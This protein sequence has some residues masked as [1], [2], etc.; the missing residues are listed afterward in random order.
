MASRSLDDLSLPVREA[1]L[2]LISL[3]QA[4]GME[5]LVYCTLRSNEEQAKLYASG[6]TSPGRVLTNARPGES[7]HNPGE[8]GK[9]WAFD[10]VPIVAGKPAWDDE[11]LLNKMGALGERAGLKWAGRW[12]GKLREKVHFEM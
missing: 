12:R 5:L 2:R 7:K 9:A 11:H 8:L 4:E 6:R 3:A 10:A 1:A